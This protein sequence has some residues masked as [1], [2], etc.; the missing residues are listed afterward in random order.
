[1]YEPLPSADH[2]GGYRFTGTLDRASAGK[3]ADVF[4]RGQ[5]GLKAAGL[6]GPVPL[7]RQ[8]FARD[9]HGRDGPGS[10]LVSA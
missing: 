6:C 4:C 8:A 2:I 1:M 3:T 5:I 10:A 9:R 7:H